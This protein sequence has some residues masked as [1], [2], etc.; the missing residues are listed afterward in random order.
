[1]SKDHGRT[2]KYVHEFLGW[3]ERLDSL[4][5]NV[6]N[7]MLTMVDTH[8]DSRRRVAEIYDK[9]LKIDT[10]VHTASW[11]HN[12][13]NQYSV[14]VS[15]R[16]TVINKLNDKG[17]GTGVMWPIGCHTQPAYKSKDLLQHTDYV[18]ER[19]LSLP[20]WPYMQDSE[21]EYVVKVFNDII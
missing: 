19:V 7:H 11:C 4:Q 21:I 17:I 16:E 13:Y 18:A 15:K 10:N 3:N 5:A 9:E 12:V 2:D 8:N 14:L 6:L 20:C 1:M